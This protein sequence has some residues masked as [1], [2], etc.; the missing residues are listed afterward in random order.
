MTSIIFTIGVVYFVAHVF[1]QVFARTR[2]PDVLLL[3]LLGIL[4]GP[5]TGLLGPE[6]F[7]R[8]GEV[9]STLALVVILFESGTSLG[10]EVLARSMGTTVRLT[11]ATFAV[12]AVLVAAVAWGVAG[13]P[14]VASVL[15]GIIAG[16]TSSAVV[17][18]LVAGL[19]MREDAGTL[20]VLESA[21]TDV[22]CIVLAVGV[23][24]AAVAGELH[25][26]RMLGGILSSLTFAAVLG[27]TGGFVWLTLLQYV[28]KLPS[29]MFMTLAFVFVLYGVSE[30]LGFSGGISALAFGFAL[31][32]QRQLGFHRVRTFKDA[33]LGELNPAE[34]AFYAEVVFLLKLAFFIYLGISL[35][36]DNGRALAAAGL[37][38]AAVFGA[39]MLLTRFLA[40][41]LS[42]RDGA[43][44][45]VMVPKGLAAAVLA[46]MPRAAGIPGG[47]ALQSFVYVVVLLSITA[48][49]VLVPLLERTRFGDRVRA[50]Y[51]PREEAALPASAPPPPA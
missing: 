11:L 46:G 45:A 48:T 1:T 28:R 24:Q 37:T 42:A 44:V 34:R 38:V 9:A 51:G 29:S 8:V 40:G 41:G 3:M 12:T 16:G 36:V 43:L 27:I 7:G 35:R 22:L 47:E 6:H 23:T 20:L 26:G 30:F 17:I 21:L 14:P 10:L 5:V 39:R 4:A 49:A 25:A 15:A 32:N 50:L 18:P 2:I 19:K 13:V 33:T 31:T